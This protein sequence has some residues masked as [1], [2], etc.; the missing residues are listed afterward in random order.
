MFLKN[1]K[2]KTGKLEK[3]DSLCGFF[4]FRY[5]LICTC[6]CVMFLCSFSQGYNI[7]NPFKTIGKK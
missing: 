2:L 4:F 7:R 1:K 6:L 5:L 3:E